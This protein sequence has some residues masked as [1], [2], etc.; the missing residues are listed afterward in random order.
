MYHVLPTVACF[1]RSRLGARRAPREARV[2]QS[3]RP[4]A[5]PR[6]RRDLGQPQ[7]HRRAVAQ[8][9]VDTELA[10]VRSRD[11]ARQGETEPGALTL[12]LGGEERGEDLRQDLGWDADAGVAH[13][14]PDPR[15]GIATLGRGRTPDQIGR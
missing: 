2:T 11:L 1:T 8:D 10:A 15:Y 12:G 4:R 9:D 7:R 14:E 5:R 3:A 6:R 13:H